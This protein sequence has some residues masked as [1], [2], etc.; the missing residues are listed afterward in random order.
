VTVG[1]RFH[2]G[3]GPTTGLNSPGSVVCLETF[4]H[5]FADYTD[6]ADLNADTKTRGLPSSMYNRN[7]VC[8]LEERV[9][10]RFNIVSGSLTI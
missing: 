4:N 2:T 7:L 10:F 3:S 1:H 6:E 9:P 5:V 8:P